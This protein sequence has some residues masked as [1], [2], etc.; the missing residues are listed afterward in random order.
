MG[1]P[2]TAG[3]SPA[4]L[5]QTVIGLADHLRAGGVEVG[6]LEI[7]DGLLQAETD[8]LLSA[9]NDWIGPVNV[10]MAARESLAVVAGAAMLAAHGH[11]LMAVTGIVTSSP[12]ACREVELAG[13]G[14]CVPTASLGTVLAPQISHQV[15][16][17]TDSVG[18][19][20]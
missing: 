10:V 2:S 12:L 11:Q 19:V 17:A 20:A 5:R 13:I 16:L 3:C 7:A 14:P 1:W 8:L 6:I 15:M 9:I 18:A 4:E